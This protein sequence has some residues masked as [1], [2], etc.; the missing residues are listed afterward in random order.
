APSSWAPGIAE[1][2]R[3]ADRGRRGARRGPEARVDRRLV[4]RARRARTRGRGVAR[5]ERRARIAAR[6]RLALGP[7][8]ARSGAPILVFAALL[9]CPLPARRAVRVD[10]ATALRGE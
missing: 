7:A 10:P 2:A 3:P 6:R 1:G 4:A 9:G 5:G 8:R